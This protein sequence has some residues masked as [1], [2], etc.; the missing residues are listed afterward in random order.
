MTQSV[1]R[2][3]SL[4]GSPRWLVLFV[5]GLGSNGADLMTFADYWQKSM[6]DVA[7]AAPSAP[8]PCPDAP[9]GFQWMP[10]LPAGHP[11]LFPEVE[12][13]APTLETMLE[14]ELAHVGLG[15]ERLALV[16][17]SQGT[18]L[19]L[20]VGLRQR[21][22]P[23]AILG[24]AGGMVGREHLADEIACKPPVML[25]N[26][27]ADALVPPAAQ[28]GVLETLQQAGVVAAGQVLPSLDHSVNADALIL[29]ARFLISAFQYRDK[30]LL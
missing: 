7:F 21:I 5:H 18:M 3:T 20:H 25:V 17:F 8:S 28:S 26:G 23:A 10:K 16:G 6:P 22:A 19:S 12:A 27:G 15:P 2:R 1:L 30:H 4:D 13:A 29:G 24:F 9:G 14:E 11:R